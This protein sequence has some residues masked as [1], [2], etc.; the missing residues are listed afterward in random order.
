MP[1]RSTPTATTASPP[2]SQ[3]LDALPAAV[4]S[5]DSRGRVILANRCA[6]Q[7]LMPP[8]KGQ[9]WRDIRAREFSEHLADGYLAS[10]SG[11]VLA[12]DT[13]P[14]NHAEGQAEGQ[15][16]LLTDVSET[17]SMQKRADR[18]S[19]LMSMGSTMARLAHQVRT[20]IAAALLYLG[21]FQRGNIDEKRQQKVAR[22]ISDR[23]YCVEQMV[24]DMLSFTYGV[25]G[26]L[27][28]V[29][30]EHIIERVVHS[31]EPICSAREADLQLEVT[32]P[33]HRLLIRRSAVESVILNLLNN[34]LEHASLDTPRIALRAFSSAG[35]VLFVVDDNG[36][37]VPCGQREQIFQPFMTT[38]ADG[39]GL[40][41][42]VVQAVAANHQGSVAVSESP[43][44]GGARFILSLPEITEGTID[45][46][47]T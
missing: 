26:E 42:P 29:T 22:R 12:I 47:S 11:Q 19:R 30:V 6:Q 13:S 41:L 1:V 2:P 16:V 15:I 4:L 9:L 23:L 45:D 24:Q 18:E 43:E 14:V 39:T 7:W 37:G 5:L 25:H 21:Q 46:Q 36:A 20:P 8:L 33:Q 38:R 44:L 40:G 3:L 34:A 28:W 35:A 32:V 10:R 17:H 31:L 27:E